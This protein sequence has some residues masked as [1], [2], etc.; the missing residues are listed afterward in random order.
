MAIVIALRIVIAI[1]DVK[2][3]SSSCT[4]T[5]AATTTCTAWSVRNV[6]IFSA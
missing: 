1:V 6:R 5:C 3:T 4:I 2:L